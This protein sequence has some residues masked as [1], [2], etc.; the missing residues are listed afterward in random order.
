MTFET[1]GRPAPTA[2]ESQHPEQATTAQTTEHT[3]GQYTGAHP[4]EQKP[5][6]PLRFKIGVAL[7]VIYPFL[8]LIIPVAPFLPVGV[9]TAAAI[10]AG[11]IGAAEVLLLV[12]IACM[13]KEGYQA[14]KAGI[15]KWMSRKS[16]K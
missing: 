1:T 15:R 3:G 12:A 4:A 5:R 11:V 16:T 2:A 13:G 9:G 10:T 14:I 8:Y 6:K 7:L